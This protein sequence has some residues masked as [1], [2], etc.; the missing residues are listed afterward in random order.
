MP[1]DCLVIADR[2]F[3]VFSVAWALHPRRL[4]V[5]L[6]EQRVQAL[7]GKGA[8]LKPGHDQP[9]TWRPS[10][11]DR[12]STPGLPEDALIEGRVVVIQI[13]KPSS[14]ERV[15]LCL[16][17]TEETSAQELAR[18]YAMRWNVETDLR[19]L[20]KT[21][22]LD[23]VRVRSPEMLAIELILAVAAYNLVRAVMSLAAKQ[24][25]LAP[26][27][28]SYT[29]ACVYV[30]A[31]AIRGTSTQ[32]QLQAMLQSI[33]ARP[34]PVRQARTPPPRQKWHK[35]EKYPPRKVQSM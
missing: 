10:R 4:L 21:V 1:Q 34:L 28:L 5:R 20:K 8:N 16:F 29:R 18:L 6:T 15:N 31:H 11:H 2:N 3:G 25:G 26:R 17:T 19:S 9:F 12:E 14:R 35:R 13:V 30:Q 23:A 27:R 33:C 24:K 32:E 22:G 7:L